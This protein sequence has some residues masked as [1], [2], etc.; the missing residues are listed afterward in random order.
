MATRKN[1]WAGRVK[2]KKVKGGLKA[3]KQRKSSGV[4]TSPSMAASSSPTPLVE[5]GRSSIASASFGL[6][7]GQLQLPM[8]QEKEPKNWHK[9]RVDTSMIQQGMTVTLEQTYPDKTIRTVTGRAIYCDGRWINVMQDDGLGNTPVFR[10]Q[11][12]E[13]DIHDGEDT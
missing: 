11:I 6:E 1:P 7:A 9:K 2:K 4:S 8:G 5:T 10:P 13:A 3:L 12:T